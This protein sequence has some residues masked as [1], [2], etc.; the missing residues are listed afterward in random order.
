MIN[1]D[2]V[3]IEK[4]AFSRLPLSVKA[5][6][7]RHDVSCQGQM[8]TISMNGA[9]IQLEHGTNVLLGDTFEVEFSVMGDPVPFILPA[10][11][12]CINFSM[13]GMRFSDCTFETVSRLAQLMEQLASESDVAMVEHERIRRRLALYL[14]EE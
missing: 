14:R 3:M 8:E 2:L 7:R 9:L 10:E 13:A 6:L 5:M 11:V 12:V 1:G 4:R